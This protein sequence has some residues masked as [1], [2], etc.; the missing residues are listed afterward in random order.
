MMLSCK[1]SPSLL[2]TT[3]SFSRITAAHCF[4]G[5]SSL[6]SS[7]LLSFPLCPPG[8]LIWAQSMLQVVLPVSFPAPMGTSREQRLCPHHLCI[9]VLATDQDTIIWTLGI[10][11][12]PLKCRQNP[13]WESGPTTVTKASLEGSANWGNRSLG[14]MLRGRRVGTAG[15]RALHFLNNWLFTLVGKYPGVGA[16]KG[17]KLIKK[18]INIHR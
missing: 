9:P 15:R 18:K 2:G 4:S 1:N 14:R 12:L 16:G 10:L 5:T 6:N 11:Y 17:K 13:W 3:H 7:G 8:S